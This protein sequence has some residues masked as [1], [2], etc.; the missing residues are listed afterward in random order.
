MAIPLGSY[1]SKGSGA[2]RNNDVNL[3]RTKSVSYS[4]TD[5]KLLLI[6]SLEAQRQLLL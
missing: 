4:A 2:R 1:T 5:N 3:E 6:Y